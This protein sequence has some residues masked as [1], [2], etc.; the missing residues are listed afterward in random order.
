MLKLLVFLVAGIVFGF[1]TDIPKAVVI[2]GFLSLLLLLGFLHFYISRTLSQANY[3]FGLTAFAL[4]F[5][6]GVFAVNIKKPGY[7]S[8]HYSHYIRGGDHIVFVPIKQLKPGIYHHRYE[9]EIRKANGHKASGKV[10]VHIARDSSSKTPAIGYEYQAR[11][12]LHKISPP[13]NPHQFNYK[14]YLRKQHI[15]HQLSLRSKDLFLLPGTGQ[16][17]YTYAASIRLRVLTALKAHGFGGDTLAVINALLLGQRQ[18]ISEKVYQ[19]YASAGAIHI[20]AISGLHVGILLLFLHFLLKPLEQ[21]RYGKNLKLVFILLILWSFAFIAGLPASAVRAVSMFSFVALALR[22][23]R[24]ADIRNVLLVSM[25]FLLLARPAFLFDAGFQLS[26]TAVFSIVWFQPVFYGCWKPKWKAA[27]WFWKLTTVSI[28]AQLGVLPLSLYYFHQ[29]PGLFFLSNLVIVPLLGI[30]LGAGILVIA[31]A[32]LQLLPSFLAE[33]Y[34]LVITSMNHLVSWIAK[35][36]S[37]IFRDIPFDWRLLV[38]FYL[39]LPALFFTL[40][41]VTFRRASMLLMAILCIQVAFVYHRYA[42]SV[43]DKFVIFHRNRDTRMAWQQGEHLTIYT[44]EK[45][46][47]PDD[48]V[49]Q[50][51]TVSERIQSIQTKIPGNL[52]EFN[53]QQLLYIDSLGIYEVK[54]LQADYILL[55]GSPEI[56]LERVLYLYHP[57]MV[58]ADGSNYPSLIKRWKASCKKEKLPFHSTY[59]KGAFILNKK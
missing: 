58:I 49:L 39:L 8:R 21:L 26:Y 3:Y 19:D 27:D 29:F 24:T 47:D 31:L 52:Y 12:T 42:A 10:L 45:D 35:Q 43:T 51:Y 16:T 53:G 54:G 40:Q 38:S 30:I 48:A 46:L 14:E 17:P 32:L 41:K 2:T 9:A 28:A 4:V 55:G 1:Y 59:E 20:L 6:I 50:N 11:T 7:S 57:K 56:N 13:R 34:A 22:S 15:Y 37:F 23:G 18:D 25:F 44:R 33:G 5:C 36:E